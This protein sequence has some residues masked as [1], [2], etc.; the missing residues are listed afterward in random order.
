MSV[1][2]DDVVA[3]MPDLRAFARSLVSG[4]NALA[5]D[6]VQD[7]LVNALQAQDQFEEGSN[8]RGW[9][10]TILRNRFFSLRAR[11]YVTSEI[12]TDN[13]E[14]LAW[15]APEQES[16][17]EVIAFKRAFAALGS[18][19]REVLV[20]AIVQ[21]L[22]YEEVARI[23]RCEVG[24]VKSRINRARKRLRDLLFDG[25][26]DRRM[27]DSAAQAGPPVADRRKVVTVMPD[28]LSPVPEPVQP[29]D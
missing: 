12:G 28:R 21:G 14:A 20:L 8:L 22:P 26:H 9:L 27:S 29:A 16:R 2:R 25:G 4:N 5:D 11:K 23:C 10:F 6:L 1:C 3:L 13:L 17:I 15:V 19:H 18:S 7:T 24:T